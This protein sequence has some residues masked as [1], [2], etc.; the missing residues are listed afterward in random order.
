MDSA[1]IKVDSKNPRPSPASLFHSSHPID[2]GSDSKRSAR[3]PDENVD[4]S[5]V[6]ATNS[7]LLIVIVC[8]VVLLAFLHIFLYGNDFS[9]MDPSEHYH[10][11]L[12]VAMAAWESISA[13]GVLNKSCSVTLHPEF[14]LSS[15]SHLHGVRVANTKKEII[16]ASVKEAARLAKKAL[17]K[18]DGIMVRERKRT[19]NRHGALSI[20]VQMM[21]ITILNL[22][23]VL[24]HLVTS[25]SGHR[26]P[27]PSAN[28]FSRFP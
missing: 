10:Q 3:S 27:Q 8:S 5:P 25:S 11:P 6:K 12:P 16:V 18:F 26:S 20:C 1:R 15:L 13:G 7:T 23:T 24:S 14:F 28:G 17:V 21:E 22:H 9:A 4:R 2:G 19:S